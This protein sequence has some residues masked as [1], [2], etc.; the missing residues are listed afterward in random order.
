MASPPFPE[1]ELTE[2]LASMPKFSWDSEGP[3]LGQST[4]GPISSAGSLESQ[5]TDR[6]ESCW[7]KRT[8]DEQKPRGFCCRRL[9]TS[10][11]LHL[12][13]SCSQSWDSCPGLID[14]HHHAP[15]RTQS[16]E[17]P[18]AGPELGILRLA[19]SG[20]LGIM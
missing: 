8:G 10:R 7:R 18:E 13:G 9:F 15:N 19:L 16:D 12:R 2:P 1:Q 17:S 14:P 5:G 6:E 3:N 20:T 11:K 4:L